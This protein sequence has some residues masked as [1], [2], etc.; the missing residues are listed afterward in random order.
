MRSI[1]QFNLFIDEIFASSFDS[2]FSTKAMIL[3]AICLLVL[4]LKKGDNYNIM[5][6]YDKSHDRSN[7]IKTNLYHNSS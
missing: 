6:P 4:E 7:L 2:F 1:T 3:N 5:K